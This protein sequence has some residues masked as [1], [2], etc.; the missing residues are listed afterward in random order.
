MNQD[1]KNTL[2]T[3]ADELRSSMYAAAIAAYGRLTANEQ[4]AP[5]LAQLRDTLF[6]RLIA[7]RLRLPEAQA[8]ANEVPA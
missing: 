4:Q 8:L 7:G 3:A 2:W 6:P 1:L 5:A